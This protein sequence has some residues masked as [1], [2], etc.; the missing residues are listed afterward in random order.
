MSIL[1]T[2][3]IYERIDK[4]IYSC[5]KYLIHVYKEL[6]KISKLFTQYVLIQPLEFLFF[7]WRIEIGREC[8]NA[9]CLGRGE[10]DITPRFLCTLRIKKNHKN[11]LVIIVLWMIVLDKKLSEICT[12]DMQALS[13]SVWSSLFTSSQKKKSWK[14]LLKS[15]VGQLQVITFI[16]NFENDS[17]CM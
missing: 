2:R 16:I 8:R 15:Y 4:C 6:T 10:W 17:S 11:S 12:F 13:D 1:F 3:K 7:S 14:V 5:K 9:D